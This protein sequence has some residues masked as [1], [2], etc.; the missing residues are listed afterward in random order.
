LY[1]QNRFSD[2]NLLSDQSY[3]YI[4]PDPERVLDAPEMVDDYYLN[5]LDWSSENILSVALCQSVYLWH[6]NTGQIQQV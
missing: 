3:R 4:S 5:L 6:A 2:N 1:S